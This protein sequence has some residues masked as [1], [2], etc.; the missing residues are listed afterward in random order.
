MYSVEQVA[1]RLRLHVRTVRAYI[2]EG[3]LEAFKVGKQYRITAAALAELLGPAAAAP[4]TSSEATV[5]SVVELDGIAP[6]LASRLATLLVASAQGRGGGG[7]P[8]H[9]Q[10]VHDATRARLKIV[11]VGALRDVADVLLMIDS[12][13]EGAR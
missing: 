10:T 9:V 1:E 3:R 5:T 13:R 2:R 7:E 12:F 6:A 8:L 11:A 4:A